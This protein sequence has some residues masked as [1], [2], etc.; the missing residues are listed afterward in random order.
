MNSN[1]SFVLQCSEAIYIWNGKGANEHERK[2]AQLLSGR[3]TESQNTSKTLDVVTLEEGQEVEGFWKVFFQSP[4]FIFIFFYLF[5][6]GAW[7]N[8][9]SL[10]S[11]TFR[12]I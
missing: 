3:V 2:N 4:C 1:D 7:I 8:C 11:L 6:E 12:N 10:I 9:H 5:E